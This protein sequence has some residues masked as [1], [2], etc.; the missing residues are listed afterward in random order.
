MRWFGTGGV[1]LVLGAA[2]CLPGCGD[3]RFPDYNYKMTIYVH[4]KAYSSVRHVE[5]KEHLS[6]VDSSGRTVKTTQQGEA[7]VL[8]LPDGRTVYAL[9]SGGGDNRIGADG[10]ARIALLPHIV[11]EQGASGFGR[12]IEA[13]R[14]DRGGGESTWDRVAKEQQQ[15]IKVTGPQDL[16][17]TYSRRGR[18]LMQ[19]WPMFVMFTDPTD[20]RT[21]KEV[22]P[23]SV[24]VSSITIEITSEYFT[25]R[26]EKKL[27]R[28]FWNSWSNFYQIEI[29]KYGGAIKNPNLKSLFFPCHEIILFRILLD[30]SNYGDTLLELRELR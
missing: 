6:I 7:V 24:G 3:D 22:S 13:Y 17:R 2:L 18:E 27:D 5:V 19:A 29:T 28:S 25:K 21:V 30:K 11:A 8:D 16:P 20:P 10:F 9:L 4:G 12:A 23:N 15:M 1:V 14:K 26:I